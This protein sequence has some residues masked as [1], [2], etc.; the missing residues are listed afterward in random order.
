M[1]SFRKPLQPLT[2]NGYTLSNAPNRLGPL[3]PSLS[4]LTIEE[5]K[6]L[7]QLQGYVWIKGFFERK[8]VL[9]LRKRFFESYRDTG[10]LLVD[11]NPQGA[12]S[13]NLDGICENS[14]LRIF[15]LTPQ[16]LAVL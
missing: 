5:Y 7:F 10:L 12:Q 13:K 3:N 9:E 16:A 6:R 15:L 14:S 2:S 1:N 11:S 8:E 4:D